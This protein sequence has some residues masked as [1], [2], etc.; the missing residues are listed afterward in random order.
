MQV[1]EH[2]WVTYEVVGMAE[3]AVYRDIWEPISPVAHLPIE[4]VLALGATGA[5]ATLVPALRASR[6]HPTAALRED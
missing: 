2:K 3:D 4:Q 5:V 1:E 6:L